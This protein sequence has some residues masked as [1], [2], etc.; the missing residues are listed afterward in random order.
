M[1]S[2]TLILFPAVG[3]SQD[4]SK[5][6]ERI[7]V[8]VERLKKAGEVLKQLAALPEDK[9]IPKEITE[10]MNLISI[11]PDAGEVSLL[12]SKA[13]GG[14]GVSSLKEDAG[15]SLPSYFG[16]GQSTG[17]DLSS[18]GS[19][20]FDF[21]MIVVN[22]KYK[23]TKGKA[24]EKTDPPTTK[25]PNSDKRKVYW[26]AFTDGVLKPIPLKNGVVSALLGAQTTVAYDNKLNKAVYGIK[27][28]DVLRGKVDAARQV[29]SEITAFRDT[30]NQLYP[31][32]K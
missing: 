20:H 12:F 28:D 30:L 13:F 21:I 1:V 9:G 4:R 32:K 14:R 27:G 25:Q 18:I 23:K 17:L 7:S 16:L 8:A 5:D 11:I 31:A 29:P 2:L 6:D 15:W 19:K 26:Y 3:I 22:A 10:N 24:D